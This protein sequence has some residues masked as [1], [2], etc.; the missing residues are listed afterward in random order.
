[1]SNKATFNTGVIGHVDHGKTTLSDAI[2]TVLAK[3]Y[4]GTARS[5][6]QI[7]N[8]PEE[9][10][11]GIKINT[12]RVE[13]DTPSRHF[14]HAY[15]PGHA[16]LVKAMV[17][18][19]AYM[20]VAIL[21]VSATDGPMPQTREHIVLCRQ[22]GIPCIIVFVNKCDKVDDEELVELIDMETR[23]LLSQYDYPGD[24]TPIVHGSA[25]KALE[26]DAEWE[27]KVI[28]LAG[29][30]D[31]IDMVSVIDRDLLMPIENVSGASGQGTKITGCIERGTIKTGDPIAI[32]GP[33]NDVQ[34]ICTGV[35]VSS[36]RIDRG[37]A[38]EKVGIFI[39]G[40][41]PEDITGAQVLA[42]PGTIM[43]HAQ[44]ECEVYMYTQAEGGRSGPFHKDYCPEF[45]IQ[46]AKVSGT[47]ELPEGV[48]AIMPGDSVGLVVT[49]EKRAALDNGQHFSICEGDNTVGAGVVVRIR[50]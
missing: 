28:E 4:G 36:E 8:A 45:G 22:V 31:N 10:V 18:G 39:Q 17:T 15:W 6:D 49:L 50:G 46:K 16:D 26:D 33:E 1:M 43:P 11:R 3:A 47:I 24:D 21:V 30:L 14:K 12:S 20:D 27:A 42:K 9:E 23:D 29:H 5:F 48:E 34:S 32:V 38:G 40:I 13:Y 19:A 35:E 37:C 2:T 7:D 44:F 25:L 41:K